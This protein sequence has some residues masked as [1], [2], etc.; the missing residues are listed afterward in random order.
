[1][2]FPLSPCYLLPTETV[3]ATTDSVRCNAKEFVTCELRRI[4]LLGTWVN[5]ASPRS[6]AARACRRG[7]YDRKVLGNYPCRTSARAG[8]IGLANPARKGGRTRKGSTHG[9][10]DAAPTDMG[11]PPAITSYHSKVTSISFCREKTRAGEVS[12]TRPVNGG[13]VPVTKICPYRVTNVS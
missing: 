4:P 2:L 7:H 3:Y 11:M 10:E 8:V 13:A 9:G 1:M 5:S 6:R 12:R